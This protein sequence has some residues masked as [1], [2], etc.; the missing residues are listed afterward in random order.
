M[1]DHKLV[2]NNLGWGLVKILKY[3]ISYHGGT[4]TQPEGREPAHV[5]ENTKQTSQ[6]YPLNIHI[7]EENITARPIRMIMRLRQ[8]SQGT[9]PGTG[10]PVRLCTGSGSGSGAA[11]HATQHMVPQR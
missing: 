4:T 10:L 2:H 9:E 5:I 1:D 11:A 7:G 3:L 6:V 8:V